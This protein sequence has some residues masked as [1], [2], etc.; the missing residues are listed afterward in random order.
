MPHGARSSLAALILFLGVGGAS[1]EPAAGTTWT[2]PPTH[3][4]AAEKAPAADT[5]AAAPAQ[6]ANTPAA[7]PEAKPAS[8]APQSVAT[9][10]TPDRRA[11]RGPT[12]AKRVAAAPRRPHVAAHTRRARTPQVAAVAPLP[13]QGYA[14][15]RPYGYGPGYGPGYADERLERLSSAE[16]AGYLVVRRR[17]VQFPDGRTLHFYRP[18][19]EGEPY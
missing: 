12:P 6:T 14:R 18:E 15:Y 10:R 1:A 2:D 16:A 19:D 8:P 3:K 7:A 4:P 17:T 9:R 5:K 13:P 11:A